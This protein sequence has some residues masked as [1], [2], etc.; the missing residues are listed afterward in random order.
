MELTNL[1]ILNINTTLGTLA[2]T[3][4]KGAFKFKLFKLKA[5]LEKAV[6]PIAN[7]LKEVDDHNERD[8]ILNETQELD[9]PTLSE[10]ELTN[11]ELSIRDLGI[12][13]PLIKETD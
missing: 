3:K 8:E 11:I 10:E 9:L 7:S 1:Q 2:D 12:L 13:Q 6:E 5:E 4:L